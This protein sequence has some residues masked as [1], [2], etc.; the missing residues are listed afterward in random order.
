MFR[1]KKITDAS[2]GFRAYNKDAINKLRVDSNYSYT[3]ETL[4]Q[5]NEKDLL[6]GEIPIKTN[7]PIRKSRLFNSSMEFIV[8]QML[9]ILKTFLLYKPLQ[10]FFLGC[11]LYQL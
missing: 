10:F 8:K 2:S 9:I 7:P 1:V 5:A 11:R 3:L 4:I 6:I